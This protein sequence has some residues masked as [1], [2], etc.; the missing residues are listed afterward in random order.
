MILHLF[1]SMLE[2]ALSLKLGVYY[3]TLRYIFM[4]DYHLMLFFKVLFCILF[5]IFQDGIANDI[6]SD[7]FEAK[8]YP[9]VYFRSSSGK[10]SKYGGNRTKEDI[11]E[12]IEKNRDKP[13]HQEQAKG[14]KEKLKDEL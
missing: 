1:Q 11:I 7:S 6:S 9:T 12:F 8:R 10:I 3:W 2:L 4:K 5:V 14:E 13:A